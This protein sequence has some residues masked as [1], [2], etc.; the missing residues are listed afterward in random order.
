MK[1]FYA[2]A[3]AALATMSMSAQ[4]YVVG[5][6]EGL[7]WDLPG[8]EVQA[9]TDGVYEFTVK[10]LSVFKASKN[11]TTTWDGDEGFDAGCYGPGENMFSGFKVYP[12]GQT[13]DMVPW[14]SNINLP[15]KGEYTITMDFN[16]MKFTALAITPTPDDYEEKFPQVYVRGNM[17][18]WGAVSEW[19]LTI[20]TENSGTF[21]NY[22][23]VY[24]L[25]LDEEGIQGGVSFKIADSSWGSINY[26]GTSALMVTGEEWTPLDYNGGDLTLEEDAHEM[27]LWFCI[28]GFNKAVIKFGGE[29]FPYG[30][31]EGGVADVVFDANAPV[32]YFNLQGVRVANPENG[33]FI[34]RQG[35]TVTKVVL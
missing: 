29:Y 31:D 2:F 8:M 18:D 7:G 22:P 32:E 14:G 19:E 26:G 4:I 34:R 24:T 20:D 28:Y 15:Y 13:F 21:P 5:E 25:E 10:D 17:N 1:K 6:G 35:N 27:T 33:L 12:D 11:N 23:W 30:D 16:N 3:F 9:K